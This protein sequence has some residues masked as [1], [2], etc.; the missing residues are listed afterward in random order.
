M[1]YPMLEINSSKIKEN[2][3][4]IVDECHKRGIQVAGVTKVFAGYERIVRAIVDG[5]ID[6][7]A[8]SRI[9][10]LKKFKKYDLPKMLIRIPM[11]S[12]AR[13]IINYSDIALVSEFD[14]IKELQKYAKKKTKNTR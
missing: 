12:Q 14:T 8:D 7:I 2:T 5:G 9:E 1:G 3:K 11:K 6:I 13:E 4:L 10:N